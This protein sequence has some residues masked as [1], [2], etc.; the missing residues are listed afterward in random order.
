MK[1][2]VYLN[3]PLRMGLAMNRGNIYFGIWEIKGTIK[4]MVVGHQGRCKIN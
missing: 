4:N 3:V 2:T 1:K